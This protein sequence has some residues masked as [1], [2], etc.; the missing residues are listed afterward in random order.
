MPMLLQ[1]PCFGRWSLWFCNLETANASELV[2]SFFRKEPDCGIYIKFGGSGDRRRIDLGG[3]IDSI[4]VI[5][6]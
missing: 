5:V 1:A 2:L 4:F 6:S 3:A